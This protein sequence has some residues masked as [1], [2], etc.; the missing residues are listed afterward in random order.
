[1][2]GRVTSNNIDSQNILTFLRSSLQLNLEDVLALDQRR[3]KNLQLA[4][5]VDIVYLF[6]KFLADR[7][8]LVAVGFLIL[9]LYFL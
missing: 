1:V 8:T 3:V 6:C 9:S 5:R 7:H 4:F 2:N